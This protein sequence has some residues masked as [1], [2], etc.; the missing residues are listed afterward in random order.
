V[1]TPATLWARTRLYAQ[2]LRRYRLRSKV[3]LETFAIRVSDPG[4]RQTLDISI[5]S[6]S[7]MSRR[8]YEKRDSHLY[9]HG[10]DAL[11]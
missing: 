6:L 9:V 4:S 10:G 7:Q 1:Q 11:T 5:E 8:I 3:E 2:R